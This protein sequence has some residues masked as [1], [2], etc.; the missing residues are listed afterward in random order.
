VRQTKVIEES[1]ASI[2]ID[3]T[4]PQVQMHLASGRMEALIRYPVSLKHATEIDER[5]SEAV[6]KVLAASSDSSPAQ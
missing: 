2:S 6:L 5:V 3:D 1:T 4:L